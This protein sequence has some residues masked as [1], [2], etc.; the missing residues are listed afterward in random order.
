MV[1]ALICCK[2]KGTNSTCLVQLALKVLYYALAHGSC[3]PERHERLTLL[4]VIANL[5][6]M[7]LGGASAVHSLAA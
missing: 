7:W 5:D 4:N 6:C 1:F 2:D 3:H